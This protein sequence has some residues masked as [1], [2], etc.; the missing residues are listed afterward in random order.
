MQQP[1]KFGTLQ[2]ALAVSALAHAA[3]LTVRFV[4]PQGLERLF[5]EQPLEVVLVNSHDDELPVRPQA[6]AQANLA[7]GGTDGTGRATSPLPP[8][9][10]SRPGDAP[11]EQEQHSEAQRQTS[12]PLLARL[13]LQD[14]SLPPPDARAGEAQP[15]EQAQERKRQEL[16]RILGEVE[17]RVNADSSGPRRH[18]ISPATREAWYARYYGE[19]RRLI[20]ERGT[21]EFPEVDGRK[22]YG[23][24]T[25]LITVAH[26]GRVLATEIVQG[27]GNDLLDR[28]AQAIVRGLSFG[29]FDATM[30]QHADQVVVA[31]RFS[32]TRDETLQTR[33]ARP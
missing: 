12:S 21:A 2:I 4:A 17:R 11:E 26:D 30:R 13:A 28:R 23:E 10:A 1:R 29:R 7:G 32:F 31:S 6:V 16:V 14:T 8:A 20:E 15:A 22:L 5:R 19:L 33:E 9:E 18:Y 27:S 24:L 3:L 25:M